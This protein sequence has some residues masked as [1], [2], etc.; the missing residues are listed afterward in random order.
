MILI[1]RSLNR[2]QRNSTLAHELAHIDL[3]HHEHTPPGRWF[4][5]RFEVEADTLAARRLLHDVDE[6]AEAMALHPQDLASA[7]EY[8]EVTPEVL[9]RRISTLTRVEQ[10]VIV[11]R[12]DRLDPC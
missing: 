10:A 1:D 2:P 9:M 8:L 5:A 7:A 12:L 4:A 6:V 11:D 3:R